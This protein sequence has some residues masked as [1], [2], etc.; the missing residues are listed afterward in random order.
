MA[1]PQVLCD[2][3]VVLAYDP[4]SRDTV[5]GADASPG[6]IIGWRWTILSVPPGSQAHVGVKGSFTDGVATVQ[7][8]TLVCDG[9]I[10][11]G[12]T[13]QCVATNA[14]GDSDPSVDRR[15][16]QQAVIVRTNL[17]QLYLPGDY[18]YDWGEKYVNPTLRLLEAAGGSVDQ[19]TELTDCPSSYSGQDGKLVV[20]EE[21]TSELVFQGLVDL[22]SGVD[23]I[24]VANTGEGTISVSP[25]IGSTPSTLCAGD[26]QRL[27]ES[28]RISIPIGSSA[29]N[30]DGTTS[31]PTG[32]RIL[33]VRLSVTVAYNGSATLLVRVNGAT[34]LN[35]LLTTESNLSI[36]SLFGAEFNSVV[37]AANAGIIRA[38]L[39]GTPTVG[40][41]NVVVTYAEQLTS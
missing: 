31:I 39:A 29:G 26:D 35:L 4:L 32:A 6:P 41:A 1:N 40:A 18:L 10:D 21:S 36:A 33:E 30:Y 24:V 28:R 9:G 2:A 22:I 37:L 11:G 15:D 14:D 8:P 12:Y 20:V 7:N 34:P 13:I 5:L 19:F 3:D 38:I 16:A 17:Q 27:K 23:G 25:T